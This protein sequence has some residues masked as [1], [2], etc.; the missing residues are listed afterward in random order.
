M[1]G[2]PSGG[3][4]KAVSE[5]VWGL[6]KSDTLAH[7]PDVQSA[8]KSTEEPTRENGAQWGYTWA[9]PTHRVDCI[10]LYKMHSCGILTSTDWV[11]T[12]SP[13]S[14]PHHSEPPAHLPSTGVR[15]W[16]SLQAL[17]EWPDLYK[18]CR[19]CPVLRTSQQ[20]R[21]LRASG[22]DH[23][24]CRPFSCAARAAF[25]G[26]LPGYCS[27]LLFRLLTA[28]QAE[29]FL[30]GSAC[31][32][33]RTDTLPPKLGT[34]GEYP[35]QEGKDICSHHSVQGCTRRSRTVPENGKVSRPEGENEIIFFLVDD[36]IVCIENPR[37]SIR[38]LLQLVS[39]F[40][41]V[42]TYKGNI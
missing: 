19:A 37:G 24:C 1:P 25:P 29:H 32:P 3:E 40:S 39:V 23:G 35:L 21:A 16:L 36:M 30:L 22:W 13:V 11:L 12:R 26:H 27:A 10:C 14:W 4:G 8:V 34:L 5:G 7:V 28:S 41:K 38:K 42:S 17:S 9:S 18:A 2:R 33:T 15:L 31:I 20:S 6:A